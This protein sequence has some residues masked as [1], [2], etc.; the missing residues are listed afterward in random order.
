MIV[1]AMGY[2]LKKA[3]VFLL[4][5]TAAASLFAAGAAAFPSS[6]RCRAAVLKDELRSR[7]L[8][9]EGSPKPEY[10]GQEGQA[11]LA[12][13]HYDGKMRT[14]F[15][16][17]SAVFSKKEMARLGWQMFQGTT[18]NFRSLRGKIYDSDGSLKPKYI[19]Q[20]GQAQFADRHYDG[21]MR[22][23]FS[24]VSAV[25]S[26]KEMAQLGWQQF[27]GTTEN[28]RSL[29]GKL[30]DSDG[31]PKPKYIGQEGQA[32]FADG[33]YDGK[34]RTAF[35][36][37]SAVLSK[38]EMARLGWKAFQGTTA[39]FRSLRGKIYDSDGSPKPK[40]TGQEGQAQFA[41]GHYDGK[42]RLAFSNVS[43]VLSKKEMAQLGWQKFQGTTEDFRSLR[44]R[45]YDSDGS[46]KPE[47]IG[48]EGQ[49]R[50][51]DKHYEGSSMLTAFQNVSAVL[52][53]KEMARLGWQMFQGT[54]EDFRS[55]RGRIYDSDGSPKPKYTGQE[56]QAQ[57]AD[58]HY[59]GKMQLA[60]SNVS[61]V[62][63]KKEMAQLG[64]QKFQGTTEDFRSL[65][66]RIYDPDGS[67]KPKYA[68]QKGYALFV[69]EHYEGESML[70]AFQNVSAVSSKKEMAKL[71]WQKF[72]GTTADFRSLR[73]K[74]YD[75]DGSPKPEY[76]GQE[77]QAQFADEHY[78]GKMWTA[79]QNVS[80]VSGKKE[81]AQ[82]GWQ[83]FQGTTA[84]FR[85]L[86]GKIY[87]S[88][89]SLKPEYAGQEGQARFAD[90]HYDGKM[91]QAF[92]NVSAAL[93]KKE[94]A[95]LGWQ[96]FQ[97]TTADFRSLRGKIYDSD[98]SPKPKY[99]GQKGYAL[100]VD[101]HYEGGGMLMAFQNVSAVSS[102]REMAQLGWQAFQGTT[103]DF[104]S[105][106]GK[107]YDS[108][109]SPKPKYTGQEGQARFADRHYDGKMLPAF[110][111]VSAVSG[112][113]EME[114]LGWQA[115]QGTTED[116]RSLR[117]KIYD[118]DGSPKPECAGQ[119]GC[120]FFT[121]MHYEGSSMQMAFKNVSAVSSKKE[122][123][124]LG[125]QSF[126]G[127]TEDFR[128]LRGKLYDSDG[129]PKPEYIGM[130]GYAR[131]A[132]EHYAGKMRQA[133]QNVSAVSSKREMAQ[134][135]W[136]NFQGTVSQLHALK[137][138]FIENYPEGWI[139]LEGQKKVADRIFEGNKRAAC[140][141]VSVLRGRLFGG[142]TKSQNRL[143]RELKWS[144]NWK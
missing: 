95:Q 28:F 1:R 90:K 36:N 32:Q 31:S 116:F 69:D 84:D 11:R 129:S 131:F 120:A 78:D 46:P 118:S 132:D 54:T 63:G 37:V 137:R 38:K 92:E 4:V 6:G 87:D 61:A 76:T 75:S 5:L 3:A 40:Y 79:F 139:G 7:I 39:D 135:G 124:R 99:T 110:S 143:F 86:R 126:Q 141:N 41:D 122:M 83:A 113:K 52:S 82:L 25:L 101:E 94:M 24:N 127:T 67:P 15:K 142:G 60:F 13:G 130:E 42:M 81:M 133:F 44:G 134:L 102:K 43:A 10:I 91:Q 140:Q 111:N 128:S 106:R 70:L 115:F 65:R 53:R 104:R 17:A 117:G 56:G 57:F 23:A 27:R 48:Q 14:A 29:R 74:I 64:W 96:Q 136:K 123:A 97:G 119:E 2:G 19:G 66:G 51:V 103:A 55:L 89:G 49:A 105:L 85:S 112:K 138:D 93:S 121:D 77:G 62:S 26:R 21:K 144:W 22:T 125:W 45:I 34:M 73:G 8:D 33:H 12:D 109:G 71:G 50:F 98:G 30:Y 114:K 47:Y 68:G 100:F 80:A 107:I 9:S 35:S 88:D 72:Q 16:N 59:D 18:E 20:E 108:D 58:E